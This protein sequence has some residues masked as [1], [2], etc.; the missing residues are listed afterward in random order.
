M[1]EPR[2]ITARD[3]A[4]QLLTA[5]PADVSPMGRAQALAMLAVAD[6]VALLRADL[7]RITAG[8][9]VP[10]DATLRSAPEERLPG[11]AGA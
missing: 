9:R 6:E 5:T 1:D 11:P 10:V 4:A 7:A 8:G 3:A 2:T